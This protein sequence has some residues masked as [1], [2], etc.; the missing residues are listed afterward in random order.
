MGQGVKMFEKIKEKKEY[1]GYTQS[2]INNEE[3][4]KCL[5]AMKI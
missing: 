4:K 3:W 5:V 1:K 2:Q